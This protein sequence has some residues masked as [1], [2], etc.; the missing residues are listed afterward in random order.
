MLAWR[1][2]KMR[3]VSEKDAETARMLKLKNGMTS[4]HRE[5][6]P[7]EYE[8]LREERRREA[9]D[10][11]R[12]GI[13]YQAAENAAPPEIIPVKPENEDGEENENEGDDNVE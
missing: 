3:E 4:L 2:P 1:W 9:E 5:L 10:A 12:D 13:I 6:G 8:R 7:G 11:R